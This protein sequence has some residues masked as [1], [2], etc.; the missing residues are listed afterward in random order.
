MARRHTKQGYT[1][2]QVLEYSCWA[3]GA[4]KSAR[5]RPIHVHLAAAADHRAH[6]PSP[7]EFYS[8]EDHR[9]HAISALRQAREWRLA[10]MEG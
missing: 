10:R 1:T 6:M 4:P 8:Y 9:T 7:R 2:S 5:L 3:A